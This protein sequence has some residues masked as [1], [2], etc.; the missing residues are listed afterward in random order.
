MTLSA[1]TN[2]HIYM[3]IREHMAEEELQNLRI[4]DGDSRWFGCWPLDGSKV[5]RR[6]HLNAF[7]VSQQGLFVQSK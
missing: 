6:V 4:V 7:P 3:C 2:S 1:M 5:T